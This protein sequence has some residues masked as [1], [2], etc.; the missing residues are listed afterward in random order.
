MKLGEIIDILDF[1]YDFTDSEHVCSFY[2][3][4]VN[5]FLLDNIE[6]V[7]VNSDYVICNFSKFI[8]EH[9]EYIIDKIYDN[10]QEEW[11]SYYREVVEDP[12]KDDET[13]ALVIIEDLIRDLLEEED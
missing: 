8:R 7:K 1:S 6:V 10:Y 3:E 2:A 11:A 12:N 9:K 5:K 4:P 13:Y